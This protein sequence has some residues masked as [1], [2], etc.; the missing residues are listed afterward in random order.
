MSSQQRC[1]IILI[2]HKQLKNI[3]NRLSILTHQEFSMRINQ[4]T[5][6]LRTSPIDALLGCAEATEAE[7]SKSE[8]QITPD[9][10]TFDPRCDVQAGYRIKVARDFEDMA[11]VIAIRASACF[12]DP[13]HLY[14]KHF[15]G[16]DFSATHLIGHIDGEPV[17]T[18]RIRYFAG[19]TRIE[20]LTV[21]PTHRRSRISFRLVKAAFA[22]CRDKGYLRLSGVAREEMVPFWSLFGGK[23][24]KGTEPIF[25]YGLPHFEMAIEFPAITTAVRHDSHP[26]VLLRPEGRWHTAG[27][28]ETINVTQ[29]LGMSASHERR[30]RD[31]AEKLASKRSGRK[32]RIPSSQDH[33][34]MG[35][36][37][38][39]TSVIVDKRAMDTKPTSF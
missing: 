29:P 34:I 9:Y 32:L 21:R 31:I 4:D 23:V 37:A 13:E 3:K 19:F 38:S 15:D 11:K 26:L 7:A 14:G 33:S 35:N 22:F 16:N 27:Y 36:S 12:S 5:N 30:P 2:A 28:H 17:G 20:R 8:T 18:I 39:N 10:D 1:V 25:I 24:S 6:S